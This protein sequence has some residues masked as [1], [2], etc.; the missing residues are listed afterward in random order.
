[1]LHVCAALQLP[2]DGVRVARCNAHRVEHHSEWSRVLRVACSSEAAA[3]SQSQAAVENV[4]RSM[5][6]TREGAQKAEAAERKH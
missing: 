3:R 5:A 4:R 6:G 2:L 1:M